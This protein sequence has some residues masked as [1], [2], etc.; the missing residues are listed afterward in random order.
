MMLLV[1]ILVAALASAKCFEPTVAHPPPDYDPHDPILQQAFES[2]TTA[3]KTAIAAPEYA[4]TS[5]SVEVTS[6]KESLWSF[7]HTAHERN[8]SRPDI[9]Q[10]NGDT[11]YRIASITKTFTVLGVLY[12]HA[13]GSLSLDD[14]VNKYL[15]ELGDKSDGGVPWKDITLRSLASQLSGIPRECK[16]P[17]ANEETIKGCCKTRSKQTNTF[18]QLPKAISSTSDSTRQS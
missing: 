5:F 17:V 4:S 1:F 13:A 9:P 6:S 16:L 12:Q 15:T 18:Y 10:V 2:I 7:H 8:A 11:L 3:L 14:T